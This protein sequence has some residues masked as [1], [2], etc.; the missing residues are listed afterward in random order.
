[1][2]LLLASASLV[3]FGVVTVKM[4]PYDNKSEI[5]VVIDMPEGTHARGDQRR[6]AGAGRVSCGR[7]RR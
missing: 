1:M 2:L 6:G 7:F 5:Q 3:A 4:L